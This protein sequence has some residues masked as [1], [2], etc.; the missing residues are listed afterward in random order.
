LNDAGAVMSQIDA[1]I[2]AAIQEQT[3]PFTDDPPYAPAFYDAMGR[4]LFVW[5]RLEKA[6][7]DLLV[8]SVVIGKSSG[9]T[10]EMYVSLSRKLKLLVN[11]FDKS[12]ELKHLH[13]RAVSLAED[14]RNNASNRNL[15]F[16]AS[17]VGFDKGPPNSLKMQHVKSENDHITVSDF[18]VPMKNLSEMASNFHLC[19][20]KILSLLIKVVPIMKQV[21][22]RGSAPS[23]AATSGE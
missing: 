14:I 22:A 20:S 8:A 23:C 19:T 21:Q 11:I 9:Q 6:L 4:T 16:H 5:G 10:H 13:E 18:L 17:L 3:K 12:P 7:D 1:E 15:V 2:I